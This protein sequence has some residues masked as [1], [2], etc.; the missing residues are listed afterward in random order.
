MNSTILNK[1]KLNKFEKVT[2]PVEGMTCA[3]CVARVEKSIKKIEGIKNVSV[4]LATEKATFEFEEGKVNVNDVADLVKEA[5]YN[6]DV[7]SSKEKVK[8]DS[9]NETSEYHKTLQRELIFAAIL[10]VPILLLSM[11]S[12]W[13]GFQNLI[14][15]SADYLNKILLILATP[16][17]FISGK[18]FYKI[19]WNNLK[20]FTADMNSLVAVGTA[21]AYGFSILVTLFPALILKPGEYPHVY[22]DTTVVIITLILMG[23]WLESRAKSK[24][25][26]AVK[27]LISLKPKTAL[28]KKGDTEIE[29]NIEDLTMGD[30]VIVKPGGKIPADGTIVQGS[31]VIDETMVTGESIPVEKSTGAKVIGGTINKTGSFNFEITAL[32]D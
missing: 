15:I 25:N 2:F 29:V 16:V 14:P 28:L 18:R 1:E 13:S 7:S 21:A 9:D 23:R 30:I 22:F 24:T 26:T 27:K 20:H 32:G 6:M 11:G 19:F 8:E 12:M 3:S 5:G 10:T 17:V 31:S 4:N